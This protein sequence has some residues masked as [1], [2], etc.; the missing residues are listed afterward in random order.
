[1]YEKF[2]DLLEED[3][4]I[5]YISA[6]Y[7]VL[8]LLFVMVLVPTQ[9]KQSQWMVL[10]ILS[11][12]SLSLLGVPIA[13]FLS[14]QV[15][16][17][18]AG[19]AAMF[20]WAVVAYF[21]Q[22]AAFIVA[23]LLPF[24]TMLNYR[25]KYK[26]GMFYILSGI[27]VQLGLLASQVKLTTQDIALSCVLGLG[28]ALYLLVDR[29]WRERI[30]RH[31]QEVKVISLEMEKAKAKIAAAE[32]G[33]E[34]FLGR[35]VLQFKE[36]VSVMMG[37]NNILQFNDTNPMRLDF[38]R[39]QF[40]TGQYLLSEFD[41]LVTGITQ[42]LPN[43]RILSEPFNL[44]EVV[45]VVENR[46]SLA[47]N[48]SDLQCEVIFN[49]NSKQIVLGDKFRL[50]QVM[51]SL[52]D[53]VIEE[54]DS[55]SE[56][57][58][59]M[60]ADSLKLGEHVELKVTIFHNGQREDE[61][62]NE[63]PDKLS[64]QYF[65]K[66]FESLG[67]DLNFAT[68]MIE[69]MESTLTISHDDAKGTY[70]NFVL[71]M[72]VAED[73]TETGVDLV[74]QDV[75]KNWYGELRDTKILVVDDNKEACFVIKELLELAGALVN[76]EHT[77]DDA[78]KTVLD[79]ETRFDC[80]IMDLQMPNMNGLEATKAI[81]EKYSKFDLPIIGLSI[82]GI[83]SQLLACLE[84]G[85]NKFSIKPFNIIDFIDFFQNALKNSKNPLNKKLAP[86]SDEEALRM[87]KLPDGYDVDLALANLGGDKELYR[88]ILDATLD[89]WHINI[90]QLQSALKRNDIHY[91]R[92]VLS[93]FANN[94]LMVG[95]VELDNYLRQLNFSL[96][97]RS[98]DQD[99]EDINVLSLGV[100][101]EDQIWQSIRVLKSIADALK[102]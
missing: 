42:H 93:R 91:A 95:A 41:Q 82:N 72:P 12:L 94:A 13:K 43:T 4:G 24:A 25:Y 59:T 66:M 64:T 92:H 77:G 101:I 65:E 27:L 86:L 73:F 100:E 21:E 29:Y 17:L 5:V 37:I 48:E 31:T 84:A 11:L 51:L 20:L 85:M 44:D 57:N 36:P 33:F 49:N 102:R 81:R 47:R 8:N 38:M 96:S 75:Q 79:G 87:I 71:F 67:Y 1:M 9:V 14:K 58:I 45:V 18:L 55:L 62:S 6:M 10:V 88:S 60:S 90:H 26:T 97:L 7:N 99:N 76:I 68:L 32:K 2:K 50:S 15:F 40:L 69:Q 78:V 19:G 30:R 52:I 46:L 53:V 89:E 54:Y 56:L 98:L 63:K 28:C 35:F 16:V 34:F 23:M 22:S 61:I 3:F 39:R 74:D 80:V 83:E 70:Y